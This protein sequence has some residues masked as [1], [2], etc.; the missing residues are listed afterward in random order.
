MWLR[1]YFKAITSEKNKYIVFRC[2]VLGKQEKKFFHLGEKISQSC[3]FPWN[4][5]H[6]NPIFFLQQFKRQFFLF[7]L[8]IKELKTKIMQFTSD[9][10]YQYCKIYRQSTSLNHSEKNIQGCLLTA[11]LTEFTDNRKREYNT[12]ILIS[13]INL[14]K[15]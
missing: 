8:L 13:N 14:V 12:W 3:I 10:T 4:M 11:R 5:K 1:S 7:C 6:K 9:Q 2:P 15:S